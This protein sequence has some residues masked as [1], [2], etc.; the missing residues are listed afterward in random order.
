M[1]FLTLPD[2]APD[3]RALTGRVETFSGHPLHR[4]LQ[5]QL[6]ILG[7]IRSNREQGIPT[8]D[9]LHEFESE[10]MQWDEAHLGDCI[11]RWM[12]VIESNI[13]RDR[14]TNRVVLNVRDFGALG[15]GV[16]DDAPAIRQAV[17]ATAERG[18]GATLRFP[19]GRYRLVPTGD[20]PSHLFI[21]GVADIV[22]EGEA[23][24][25]LLGTT[26]LAVLRL[27]SCRNV[28]LR[29]LILDYATHPYTQGKVL[30]VA[31][32]R[33]FVEWQADEGFIGPDAPEMAVYPKL[34]GILLDPVSGHM[35]PHPHDSFFTTRH[36]I[37]GNGLYRLH[38]E[39]GELHREDVVA[40]MD[41][42]LYKRL[43]PMG[44][45]I[46]ACEWIDCEEVVVQ[47]APQFAAYIESS[48][49]VSLRRCAL[50]PRAGY[51]GGLNADGYHCRSNRFGPFFEDCRIVR[52]LDDC[53]NLYSRGVGL[54]AT[55][56]ERTVVLD[57][58]WQHADRRWAQHP[59]RED[60][61]AGDVLAFMN[62]QSGELYGHARIESIH[63]Y[64]WNGYH[65]VAATLDRTVPNL[66]SRESLGHSTVG[67][68]TFLDAN[69]DEEIETFVI[70]VSTKCD[71]FVIRGCEL[72]DNTVT[73]GKIKASNGLIEGNHNFRHGWCCFAFSI[74]G[75]WLEGYAARNVL[76][77]NN[78][79]ESWFGLFLNE[80]LPERR[81]NLKNSLVRR[82]DIEGNIFRGIR[83]GEPCVDVRNGCDCSITNNTMS[84]IRP[85]M[86]SA[87]AQRIRIEGNRP[88]GDRQVPGM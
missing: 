43:G 52:V 71:G 51:H 56:D 42:M 78:N 53:F 34:Q 66:P 58:P 85:I 72:G 6:T 44:F 65:Q 16:H 54:D 63:S 30:S 20:E 31:P 69:Y 83:Q 36:D 41:M 55:P 1:N 38:A 86:I 24:T 29:R 77:R 35:A 59:R 50:Q 84:V 28:H 87:L 88:D 22:L 21:E 15:D 82:I 49:G 76:V 39:E 79:F 48:Y 80:G 4:L 37:L 73:G 23:G 13:E 33:S 57:A 70:N 64:D 40:G 32:D 9:P 5:D 27:E 14:N 7:R 74:E 25:E 10:L 3:L 17:A 47:A 75:E 2:A 46:C 26:P 62:P 12:D 81:F 8:H 61:C 68:A 18:N 19:A 67:S 11:S 60:F 45:D